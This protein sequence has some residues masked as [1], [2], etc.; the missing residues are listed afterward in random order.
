[1]LARPPMAGTRPAAAAAP[2]PQ[3]A[4]QRGCLP[5][6]A[7][8]G[9]PAR[10]SAG[11]RRRQPLALPTAF[12]SSYALPLAQAELHA[13]TATPS[14]IAPA[15]ERSNEPAVQEAE[16]QQEQHPKRHFPWWSDEWKEEHRKEKGRVVSWVLRRAVVARV[17]AVGLGQGSGK[18]GRLPA[19]RPR[20]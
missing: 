15:P 5:L 7:A 11:L 10:P 20:R 18:P 2:A 9:V 19:G 8:L 16:Q 6:A 13:Q 3:A 4:L 14:G 17:L 1:M 12:H